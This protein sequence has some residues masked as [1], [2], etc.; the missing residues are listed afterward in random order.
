VDRLLETFFNPEVMVTSAPYLV[1]GLWM[2]VRLCAVVIPL[3]MAAGLILATLH[4][5]RHRWLNVLLIIYVDLFRAFPP[6]MLLIFVY[7]GLPYVG[8]VLSPFM[9]VTLAFML[10][11]SSYYGEILRAG[12]ESI[13]H[14]QWEAA[15]S[16]GL[17]RAQ[18][19]RYVIL[20][21]AVRSVLPDLV[22]NT[23]EVVKLTSLASVVALP[24]LLRMAR[25]AQG[26]TFN[27]TPLI[28]AAGIY[29]IL[30]WPFVRLLSRMERRMLAPAA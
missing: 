16:T 6:L 5:L 26:V 21:Q 8:L 12:I 30:L 20:P 3:G 10:N 2:T 15:R 19:M 23:L 7:Y 1:R 11:T 9:A 22:S 4:H 17:G 24:E 25:L 18:T 14:G 29:F 27:P 28:L 13:P